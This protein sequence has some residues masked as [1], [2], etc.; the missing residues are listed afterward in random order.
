MTSDSSVE[1]PDQVEDLV[2]E[3]ADAPSKKHSSTGFSIQNMKVGMK[4]GLGSALIL[5]FL[6]VVA[7]TSFF[8]LTGANANFKDYRSIARQTN[9]MG[10]IQANLLSAR[11]GVKDYIIKGSDKAANAVNSRIGT[12][13][14]CAGQRRVSD[15]PPPGNHRCRQSARW[16]RFSRAQP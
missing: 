1:G 15:C 11:L 14:T 8:G 12:L 5:A 10:R 6:M 9:Q 3:A 7:G 13:E 2:I 4:I 16:P